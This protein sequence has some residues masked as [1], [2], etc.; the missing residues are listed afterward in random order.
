MVIF[1]INK[2]KFVGV[3]DLLNDSPNMLRLFNFTIGRVNFI[4]FEDQINMEK[5]TISGGK[6][7]GVKID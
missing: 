4:Y 5:N 3:V 6:L 1:D 2:M 7:K